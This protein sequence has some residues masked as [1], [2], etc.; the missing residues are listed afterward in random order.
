[1]A[2][3]QRGPHDEHP[4]LRARAGVSFVPLSS[5]VSPS[6][7]PDLGHYFDTDYNDLIDRFGGIPLQTD[8][9]IEDVGYNYGGASLGL[10]LG[11]PQRFPSRCAW[12][13]PAA[14]STIDDAERLLR[15]VTADPTSPPSR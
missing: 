14:H 2:A 13:W 7:N 6:I 10:E 12:G 4:E 9:P 11:K 5:F 1:M 3:D 15:D 8:V